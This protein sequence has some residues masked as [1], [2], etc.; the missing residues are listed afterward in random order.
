M[1]K[2]N[3]EFSDLSLRDVK[4]Y[5]KNKRY[6]I[7][8]D[9]S[10]F[11]ELPSLMFDE[12]CPVFFVST[13]RSGS[14]LLV[15]LFRKVKA[16]AVYHE[17]SPRMFLGSKLAY[18]IGD[19]HLESLKMSFLNARFELLRTAFLNDKMYIETNNRVT[20]FMDAIADIFPKSKFIH[21]VRHPGGFVRSGLRRNYYE[22]AETD[23]GRIIPRKESKMIKKWSKMSQI[24]KISWLW[25]ETNSFIEQKKNRLNNQRV[26]TIRSNDLFTDPSI[27]Q[28]I[29]EFLNCPVLSQRLTKKILKKPVNFQ[30]KGQIG[31]WHTWPK[32]EIELLEKWTPLGKVYGFWPNDKID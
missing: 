20:F 28:T 5:I 8:R 18:E 14:E 23:F 25:N 32:Y 4:A 17:P 22:G 19:G 7:K 27:F 2:K 30:K 3:K 12:M 26:L 13:G 29:C 31:E 16:G 9:I 21:I 15:K 1:R 10:N 24:E 11:S 6:K